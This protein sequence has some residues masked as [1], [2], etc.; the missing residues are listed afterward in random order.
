[1][2]QKRRGALAGPQLVVVFV[3]VI[4]AGVTDP[5]GVLADMHVTDQQVGAV[6]IL[7][8]VSGKAGLI[9][10][11]P[12]MVRVPFKSCVVREPASV[13][14]TGESRNTVAADRQVTI[15]R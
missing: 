10:A 15:L 8:E 14:F 5:N 7:A 1:M 12:D 6:L 4:V 2:E 11:R 13:I 3:V 9:V